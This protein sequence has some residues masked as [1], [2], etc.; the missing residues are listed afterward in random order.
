MHQ[1]SASASGIAHPFSRTP[2]ASVPPQRPAYFETHWPLYA[3]SWSNPDWTGAEYVAVGTFTEDTHNRVQVCRVD[4]SVD[5]LSGSPS[6]SF[7]TVGEAIV[8][9][10]IT[11]LAWE[12]A[13]RQQAGPVGG[14]VGPRLLSTSDC[15]RIW[16]L[17]LETSKLHQRAAL[18]NK[19]KSE[20]TPPITSF[21]WNRVEPSLVITSSIDTTCTVWDISAQ[22]A[23]TQLIAH[24]SEVY[25]VAFAADSVDVF[26]SVGADGS[27]RVF[28]LRALDHSTIIYEPP[29]PVPLVRI[30]AN[31]HDRN[32]LATMAAD[33]NRIFV[34][35]VRSPA[36]PI[37]TL[38][39]HQ[40][41]INSISWNPA[42]RNLLASGSDDH[43]VLLWDLNAEATAGPLVSA[44][45][46]TAEVNNVA[47]S[48]SGDWLGVVGGRGFQG[49]TI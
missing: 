24:D 29:Q 10:P 22:S 6:M 36:V 8:P 41:A 47:W 3:A 48:A 1:P 23:R 42:R 34:L 45:T 46:D 7:G 21:D 4:R 20:Y 43:Q 25:D 37:A 31:P 5:A 13:G 38:D 12:P 19:S 44:Y 17:E 11:K 40:R 14:A 18:V 15:L 32:M 26:A 30:A 35:D 9:Y 28:D 27:V 33:S 16:E 49:I 2:V 39:G